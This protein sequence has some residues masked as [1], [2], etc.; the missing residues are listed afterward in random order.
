MG[1]IDGDLQTLTRG[2]LSHLRVE[3]GRSANTIA[4]YRRDLT[5][6]GE[7]L[8]ARNLRFEQVD[9][10]VI[11]GFIT[12]VRTAT[13]DRPALAASSASRLLASVRGLHGFAAAEG[14]TVDNAAKDLKPPRTAQ[15]LPKVLTVAEVE[16][17][18]DAPNDSTLP[19]LRDRALLEFLYSTGAR[20]TEAVSL[21]IDDLELDGEYPYARV[22]GKGSKERIVPLGT[23]AAAALGNYLTKARP[24]FIM[25]GQGTPAVFSN[26]RGRR[27]SRQSAWTI[28]RNAAIRAELPGASEV[29][30]HTLRHCFAT[31]LLAGGADVRVV[32]E[33]LGH[34]SVTTT[35]L[36]THVTID[37]LREVYLTSHPRAQD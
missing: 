1:N 14:V 12:E 22:V 26:S 7:Y 32:Q 27:L 5:R 35:Q 2:F 21:D 13:P 28:I 17:L 23:Y 9:E 16:L 34:A 15:Q 18:L 11:D 3:R 8:A 30:P 37:A 29:T 24:T 19:G 10:A 4:A 20:I 36:Y 31:H 33:L 6:Y 25:A